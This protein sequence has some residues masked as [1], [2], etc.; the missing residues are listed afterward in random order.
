MVKPNGEKYYEYIVVY[1]DDL[2]AIGQNPTHITD[3]LQADP[4]NYILKDVQ[5]PKT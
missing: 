4:F 2:L 1:I 3:A 5:E